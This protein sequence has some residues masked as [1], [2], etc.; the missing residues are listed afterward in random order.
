MKFLGGARAERLIEQIVSSGRLDAADNAQR[1]AEL[2]ALKRDVVPKLIERLAVTRRDEHR[3]IIA[4]LAQVLDADTLR[5][6]LKALKHDDAQVVAGVV[7]ALKQGQAI[8]PNAVLRLFAEPDVPKA[9][10]LE[11]LSAYTQHL[12]AQGLLRLVGQVECGNQIALFGLIEACADK[13]LVPELMPRTEAHDP[14]VRAQVARILARF[15]TEAVRQALYKLLH[16][17]NTHVRLAAL[18]GLSRLEGLDITRLTPLLWEDDVRLQTQ[19]IGLLVKLNHPHTVTYLLDA[20]Q[21]ESEYA[22]RG[23]VEVLN[24]L[25]GPDTL[26]ELLLAIKDRDWWVRSRAADALAKVGGPRVIESVMQLIKS[27]DEFIRRMAIEIIN[28]SPHAAGFDALVEALNDSDWWVRGRAIDGLAT[29]AGKKAIPILIKLFEAESTDETTLIALLQAFGRLKAR[30]ALKPIIQRLNNASEAVQKAAL[31][32]LKPILEMTALNEE[33]LH[34]LYEHHHHGSPEVKRLVAELL[35]HTDS[36]ARSSLALPGQA[37]RGGLPSRGDPRLRNDS[38]AADHK[39]NKDNTQRLRSAG[40]LLS[41]AAFDPLKLKAG[42]VIGGRY[43]FVQFIGKGAFGAVLL[44]EDMIVKEAVVLKFLHPQVAGDEEAV[45]RFIHELRLARKVQHPNIIRTYDLITF[46]QT[47]AIGMEY[48]PSHTLALEIRRKSLS[49]GRA[50]KI[51]GDVCAGMVSAHE[52][53]VIHRDLKPA[54][55]LISE[56]DE[57]KIVDFGIASAAHKVDTHLTQA[58]TLLGTPT[59]MAPEQ[60][61]GEAVDTRTDIY[62]L[63]VILYEVLTGRPP[64]VSDDQLAVLYGHVQ[65]N[66]KPPRTLNPSIPHTLNT[67]VLKAMAVSAEER[68]QSMAELGKRLSVIKAWISTANHATG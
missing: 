60:I 54:N 67:L 21:D 46:G 47:H 66:L 3:L 27:A 33:V 13:T 7:Q 45:K 14:L 5:Y 25:A 11:V 42:E 23:A 35:E 36:P 37:L 29:F 56:C 9:A 24:H 64:Y 19:A 68:F 63:G 55:I 50:L 1:F 38:P 49:F 65:G 39:D 62:S 18:E 53:G 48:F 58:G 57:V 61:T 43:R 32:A 15:D 2:R 40:G 34:A 28:A 22:R 10:L 59:Y 41:E 51:F 44:M 30:Q 12:S 52:A 8:D 31:M 20:L 16:D 6:Y 17:A 26:E 4:L